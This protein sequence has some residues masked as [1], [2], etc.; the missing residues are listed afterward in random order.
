MTL[1]ESFA[2]ALAAKD[3]D[4]VGELLHPEIDFRGLTPNFNWRATS[5]DAVITE[6]LQDWFGHDD[7]IEALE[8][9]EE[10]A[11]VDRTRIGYR[12]AVR[13]PDGHFLVEQQ[14]Y[15]AERDGRIGWLRVLCSGMRPTD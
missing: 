5:P 12:L 3:W 15:F 7:R 14:A 4:A 13:N 9:F 8:H 2:R 10:N 11:F 6:V 1:G